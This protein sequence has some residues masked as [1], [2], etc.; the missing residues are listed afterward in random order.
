MANK[1]PTTGLALK[2]MEA[3]EKTWLMKYILYLI[4]QSGNENP[5]RKYICIVL[6]VIG[7]FLKHRTIPSPETIH[8]QTG[9]CELYIC[10]NLINYNTAPLRIA[11]AVYDNLHVFKAGTLPPE[12]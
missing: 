10:Y 12:F 5:S 11:I 3:E 9:L 6:Y 7:Y 4:K 8:S 2:E 1:D